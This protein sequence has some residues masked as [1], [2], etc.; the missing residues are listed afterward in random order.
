MSD[1]YKNVIYGYQ[2]NFSTYTDEMAS[3]SLFNLSSEFYT[4]IVLDDTQNEHNLTM[5][6]YS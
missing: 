5:A 3:M 2:D 1:K 6:L 4:E